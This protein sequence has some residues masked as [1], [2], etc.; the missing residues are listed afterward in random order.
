MEILESREGGVLILEPVGCLDKS[1]SKEF[2]ERTVE[3]LEAGDSRIVIDMEQTE[4]VDGTGLREM[5]S[6]SR[7]LDG[8]DGRLVV[9]SMSEQVRKAFHLAGLLRMFS[10]ASDRSDAIGQL[11]GDASLARAADLAVQLLIRAEQ[12][13]FARRQA[14]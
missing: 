13:E 2:Q 9:C 1:A 6:L 5:L 10:I 7:R 11:S 12:R 3:I 14:G 4:Q 8:M